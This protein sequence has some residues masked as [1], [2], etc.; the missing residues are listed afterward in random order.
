LAP[1]LD[2]RVTALGKR[3]VDRAGNREYF[4]S[5]VGGEARGDER[6]RGEPRLDHQAALREPADQAV[7]AR[8]VVRKRRGAERKFADEKPAL[9]D[10]GRD[11]GVAPG[12]DHRDA[13]AE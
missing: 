9:G 13:G 11:P 10:R 3:R 7:A 6:A 8:K 1:R 12:I 4:A 5:L 2:E